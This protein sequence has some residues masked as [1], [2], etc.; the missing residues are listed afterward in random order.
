MR[1]IEEIPEM[2]YNS[3]D[4]PSIAKGG[5]RMI[6]EIHGKIS[7]SGSNLSNRLEDKLTGDIFGALRY[8]PFHIGLAQILK[9]ANL[10]HL[11]N[12]VDQTDL[13]FWGD[14]IRFWPH[15]EEGEM[16]VFLE[17]D[18]AVI[19]IEVKYN[20]GLS[21]EDD[22][23][24]SGINEESERKKSCDQLARE[25]RI[26]KS[27]CPAHKKPFL[28][29]IAKENICEDICSDK[30]ARDILEDGVE[31]GYVSWQEILHQLSSIE[32]DDPVCR[33]ML[34]DI[35]ELLRKKKF[36]R[37]RSFDDADSAP[38][39]PS[40]FFFYNNQKSDFSFVIPKFVN[41]GD[42]FEYR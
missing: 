40:H 21:S 37:F 22:V 6:A 19:C 5:I 12:C 25:S 31:L 11:S 1:H 7:S 29:F 2:N 14:R 30:L 18:N 3:I 17:L 13:T 28:I 15:H 34:S 10:P 32:A 26:I 27:W 41:G 20:S 9:A 36:D 33:L 16:D 23:D 42:C 35:V 24:N 4:T 38:I 8:L 39:D